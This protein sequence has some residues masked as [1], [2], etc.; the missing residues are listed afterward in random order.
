MKERFETIFDHQTIECILKKRGTYAI[1][2][3]YR[4]QYTNSTTVL[5]CGIFSVINNNKRNCIC[6]IIDYLAT[7]SAEVKNIMPGF[8]Y[9]LF[10]GKGLGKLIINLIQVFGEHFSWNKRIPSVIL[11]AT[12]ES[13]SFYEEIGFLSL[14]NE[15]K[16]KEMVISAKTN[17]IKI[18]QKDEVIRHYTEI[19]KEATNLYH[20]YLQGDKIIDHKKKKFIN[21]V[22]QDLSLVVFNEKYDKDDIVEKVHDIINL[23][24]YPKFLKDMHPQ[25]LARSRKDCNTYW[26]N[27]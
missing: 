9:K 3:Y 20:M 13:K 12:E 7:T 18:F 24:S 21:H 1:A 19:K 2:I 8:S 26:K 27:Y 6:L 16:Y 10:T 4:G 5:S 25:L 15:I 23:K 17:L 22:M 14:N 11:K